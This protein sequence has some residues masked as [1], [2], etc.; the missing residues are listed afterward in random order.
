MF[1]IKQMA[2][3][4]VKDGVRFTFNS[5]NKEERGFFFFTYV[6]IHQDI[7]FAQEKQI[8]FIS[9]TNRSIQKKE[10][11]LKSFLTAISNSRYK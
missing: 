2:Y 1:M 4:C 5:I 9:V 7:T 3:I 6:P 8:W 10:I 11:A